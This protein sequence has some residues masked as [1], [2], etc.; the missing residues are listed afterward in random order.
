MIKDYCGS[1]DYLLHLASSAPSQENCLLG[2]AVTQETGIYCIEDY[3]RLEDLGEESDCI[4]LHVPQ[5]VLWCLLDV[6]NC[7]NSIPIVMHTH[8][9]GSP[10]YDPLKFS[11]QDEFFMKSLSHFAWS[12]FGIPQCLAILSNDREYIYKS[13]D[14]CEVAH[15][16]K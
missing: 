15:H 13:Y 9:K 1:L 10:Y 8:C 16:D 5:S 2:C 14:S 11:Q 7:R 6:C 12:N 4:S 3:C